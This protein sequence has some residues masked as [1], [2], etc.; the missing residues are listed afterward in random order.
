MVELM[1][2]MHQQGDHSF[3]EIL[4]KIHLGQLTKDGKK[5]LCTRIIKKSDDNYPYY[6]IIL[7]LDR[8]P[9]KQSDAS[10]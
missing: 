1:K 2:I 4:N 8:L 3:T 9:V 10:C 7:L 5:K 6:I